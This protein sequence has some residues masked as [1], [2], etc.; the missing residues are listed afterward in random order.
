MTDR[1]GVI[2]AWTEA[3]GESDTEIGGLFQTRLTLAIP[4]GVA[5]V[6]ALT[7][8]GT[9]T[10]LLS[11]TSA[12]AEGDWVR[13]DSDGQFFQ[14]D[15]IVPN[16]S[17]LILNPTSRPI[18][19]GVSVSSKAVT[20]WPVETTLDW[21]SAGFIGVE[22]V[23]Y[24]YTGKTNIAF[25]GVYHLAGGE[26]VPG[27][28]KL[29]RIQ[30]TVIDLNRSHS[31]VDLVRRA[32]LV[33]YA[34]GDDL[35]ALGR[36]LGVFRLPFIASDPQF[37]EIL[38][39]L[40]YNPKG[41]LFGLEL[42]LRGLIGVGNFELYEDLI[43]YPNT[44]FVRLLGAATT[45]ARSQGKAYFAGQEIV[46]AVN[47]A[48]IPI[49]YP[50]K[51][52]GVVHNIYWA[53]EDHVTNCR[54]ARPPTDL[55]REYPG[56]GLTPAWSYQGVAPETTYVQQV[57]GEAIQFV[58]LAGAEGRYARSMRAGTKGI[59]RVE[60]VLHK[61]TGYSA[62]ALRTTALTIADGVRGMSAYIEGDQVTS[63]LVGMTP[64]VSGAFATATVTKRISD[65]DYHTVAL[66]KY[67]DVEWR[68]YVDQILVDRIPYA[69][70]VLTSWTR[71]L[72]GKSGAT[73]AF[74]TPLRVKQISVWAKDDTDFASA[75]G[76]AGVLANPGT[77]QTG[78]YLFQADDAGK[79]VLIEKSAVVNGS[80]GNNNGR[81]VVQPG[82]TG[83]ATC[84]L[85]GSVLSGAVVPGA[86]ATRITLPVAGPKFHFPDDLGRTITLSGSGLG[87][88]GTW[89]IGQLLD[90]VTLAD[91]NTGA[92]PI[93]AQTNVCEV[94]GASLVPEAGL[95][96]QLHPDFTSESGIAWQLPNS[97][98][99]TGQLL[100]LRM[101]LPTMD[102][103]MLQVLAINYSAV[104]SAQ[105]LPDEGV[106]NAIIQEVPE[107]WFG[108]YPLYIADPM[109]FVRTYLSEI[110]AAGVIP[111]FQII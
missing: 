42:A 12:L 73:G 32:M 76:V 11:D 106:T 14:I 60:A 40:A 5:L 25:Q 88:N 107:L 1:A 15:T 83:L 82:A 47:T 72:V 13:L 80:G 48:A 89:V 103:G 61:L 65:A 33:D 98:D 71:V 24:R 79:S 93:A 81:W 66:E 41:T 95:T 19:S 102:P 90:P 70:G 35:N 52:R 6:T 29:L 17:L 7:W 46:N 28:A 74:V 101:A 86:T 44:V 57:A 75:R 105:V 94:V 77:F 3:V 67:R 64:A 97:I 109:G 36:N 63:A 20:T 87:N 58:G 22:G 78:G 53:P 111:D 104:L 16:T 69:S 9:T 10:I 38:K 23:R 92:T 84:T 62:E 39:A 43:R 85:D 45:D 51:G 34:E 54:I 30:S 100:A 37:R 91:L 2:Q 110:T 31:G 55:M 49:A 4:T 108:Y 26:V 27:P 18:P 21:D 8:N 50:I 96:W 56:A 59:I 68:L 99:V